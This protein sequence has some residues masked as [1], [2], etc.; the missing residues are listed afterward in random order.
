MKAFK[1]NKPNYK[2]R[3][4]VV[5]TG[6]YLVGIILLVQLFNLQIIHGAEYRET[7]N[8]RLTREST[9]KA[10][11]G[12]IT[13][14]SGE[15]I[16]DTT[17]SFSLEMYKSKI[18]NYTL[19]DTL[20]KI[21]NVLEQ[22]N[23]NYIDDFPISVNPFAFQYQDE[24]R[25]KKWKTSNKLDENLTAEEAFYKF[26][27][28]YKIENENV[29]ETRKIIAMR[30]HISQ[31]G[32]SATKSVTLA[33]NISVECF[34]IFNEQKDSFPGI[35]TVT[36]PVRYYPKGT[37]ASHIIGYTQKITKDQYKVEKDNGYT[38]N[39]FYG[40]AGIEKI[41]EKYLK[42]TDGIKQIDMA[43]D[44]TITDENVRQEAIQG[45]DVIL[46]IDANLQ[47]VT[48]QA[49]K[50]NVEKIRNGGFSETSNATGGAMV[51]MDVKT[52]EILAMASYPDY[53][54]SQFTFGIAP[55]IYNWYNDSTYKPLRNRAIQEIYQPGSIYKMVTAV[56]G[57]ETGVITKTTKINDTGRY[58][59]YKD[60]QPYCWNH[61]GHGWMNV[62]SAIQH[63]CNYFFYET[64]RLAGI[65]NLARYTKYFGLG[66]K[67]GIEL[68]GEE[69]GRLNERTQG[70]TWNP[71]N[72]IQAAIG[73][74]NNLFTPIQMAK[75]TSMLA[76]GGN[77]VKPTIIKAIKN[78]DGTEVAR[79][80]YE[81]YFNEKLGISEDTN[82]GITINPENLKVV[83]QGMKSVTSERGG[84]AYSYFKNF[85]IEVGGKTGSAQ[86]GTDKN[87]N[88]ITHAWFI[89]FAPFD[90]PEIAVVILVENGGHGGYTAEAA[91]DVMAQ[92][93]GMN[94]NQV[95]EDV[96]AIPYT[97]T[98]N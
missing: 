59:Y 84:T 47:A 24:E 36:M 98:Q 10:A 58:T 25:Q 16:V 8:T 75:Y 66:K 61:S 86:A 67:T 40:Q 94:A 83:L 54:P 72:T 96:T 70:E 30:Y 43:V 37:L 48:E 51:V 44:G 85:N 90:D 6:V 80:E 65:D 62:T 53:D 38:I 49:L 73:Q 78:V 60:F 27:E 41:A 88:E 14:R 9:L 1:P 7:S 89:G 82:D 52:G 39:D 93:F 42:G 77:V 45:S 20:L 74:L 35:N 46:T 2:F 92:Y 69:K 76:N 57:L 23:S 50:N 71:G 79:E 12:A 56:T 3:Y 31:E 15:K 18:D 11:R 95:T 34:N 22:N 68:P 28:K 21:A 32:Y 64:G 17:T 33:N 29:E 87:G 4:N 5:I 81:A 13:D 26:K 91:R 19:N 55:E 63:S 97:Q